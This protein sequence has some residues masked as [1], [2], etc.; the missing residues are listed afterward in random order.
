MRSSGVQYLLSGGE[1]HS[2]SLKVTKITD[3]SNFF[4]FIEHQ[5][6]LNMVGQKPGTGFLDAARWQL[7]PESLDK[8]TYHKTN[9]FNYAFVDGS[10]RLIDVNQ[11]AASDSWTP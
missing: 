4:Q 5:S 11:A 1:V 8:R 2:Q 3:P 6:Q 10:V 7:S 9:H